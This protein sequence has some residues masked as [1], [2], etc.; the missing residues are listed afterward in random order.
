MWILQNSSE[1]I[2]LLWTAASKHRIISMFWRISHHSD[3]FIVK[4]KRLNTLPWQLSTL[5]WLWPSFCT[6]QTYQA[7]TCQ[8]LAS[9][10]RRFNVCSMSIRRRKRHCESTGMQRRYIDFFLS[11]CGWMPLNI[12]IKIISVLPCS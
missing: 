3:A 6:C 9:Q 1:W 8:A 12:K 10:W 4:F 11:L 5:P 2:K 7:L